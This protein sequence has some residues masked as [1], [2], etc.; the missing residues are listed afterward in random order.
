MVPEGQCHGSY[1]QAEKMRQ[2][3]GTLFVSLEDQGRI[4]NKPDIIPNNF[5]E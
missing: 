3:E 1:F 5:R 2:G 4:V